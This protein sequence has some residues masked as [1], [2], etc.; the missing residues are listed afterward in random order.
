VDPQLG[1]T[2]L[3][4]RGSI[5]PRPSPWLHLRYLTE[6]CDGSFTVVTPINCSLI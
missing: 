2:V 3:K 4:L 5:A 6:V 1:T